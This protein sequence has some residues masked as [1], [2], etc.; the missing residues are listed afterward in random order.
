MARI[1]WQRRAKG[2]AVSWGFLVLGAFHIFVAVPEPEE[3]K[4]EPEKSQLR[5]NIHYGSAMTCVAG[6]G[7]GFA[8]PL[9]TT[10]LLK[11]AFLGSLAALFGSLGTLKATGQWEDD[12]DPKTFW[13]RCIFCFAEY[14]LFLSGAIAGSRPRVISV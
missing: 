6:L 9:S 10:N 3:K 12:E 8:Q 13:T 14:A 11:G 7:Y 4:S 5:E 1:A 2:L